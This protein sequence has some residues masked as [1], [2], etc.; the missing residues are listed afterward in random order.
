[1]YSESRVVFSLKRL[2]VVLFLFAT[3]LFYSLTSIFFDDNN[4]TV[5]YF[6]LIL[7]FLLPM[8]YMA[9]RKDVDIFEPITLFTLYYFAAVP[10]GY[11]FLSTHFE[12][13]AYVT[14]FSQNEISLFNIAILCL[15]FGYLFAV[16]GYH[17]GRK[18]EKREVTIRF[19]SQSGISDKVL[20]P[21]IMFSFLLG[22]L[23]F[24]VNIWKISGGDIIAYLSTMSIRLALDKEIPHTTLFYVGTYL[25][26]YL[27]I[28]YLKRCQKNITIILLPLSVAVLMLASTGRIFNT[29]SYVLSVLAVYYY[30]YS[31]RQK[32]NYNRKYLLVLAVVVSSSVLLYLFRFTTSAILSMESAFDLSDFLG[33]LNL[34]DGLRFIFFETGNVPNIPVLMKII[35]SWGNEI[36]FLYGQSLVSWVVNILPS[37]IRPEG[38]QPSVMI[39]KAGW[40]PDALGAHPPTGIGEMYANFGI[41][42]PFLGMFSFGYFCAIL[43]NLLGRFNNFW[44]LVAYCQILTGFVFLYAKGEFDNLSLWQ[45]LPI[46]SAY[47]FLRACTLIINRLKFVCERSTV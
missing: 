32:A 30:I 16:L 27:L 31:D 41:L 29:I 4:L 17:A 26:I 1:M 39:M 5:S 11:Y 9:M 45:I 2:I 23:N 46:A 19:E 24:N 38:Y 21:F 43:Y 8:S 33:G 25:S 34:A 42:G 3:G 47:L 6:L 28:Y 35:D 36:G 40:F 15:I 37:S 14:S 18:K 22:V 10:S 20:L 12:K 44:M 13:G 7:L